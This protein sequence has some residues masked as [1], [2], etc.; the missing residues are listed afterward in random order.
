M[1]AW[2]PTDRGLPHLPTSLLSPLSYRGEQ[3]LS[4]PALEFKCPNERFATEKLFVLYH[5]FMLS[6]QRTEIMHVLSLW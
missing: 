6:L 3:A 1:E 2:R 5:S 4:G